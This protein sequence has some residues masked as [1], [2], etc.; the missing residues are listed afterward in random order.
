[1]TNNAQFRYAM[2]FVINKQTQ[3]CSRIRKSGFPWTWRTCS[4]RVARKLR[5]KLNCR[6][7]L[8]IRPEV[9]AFLLALCRHFT[10]RFFA[11]THHKLYKYTSFF[12]EPRK[13]GARARNALLTCDTHTITWLDVGKF[14]RMNR[15]IVSPMS[16]LGRR[17]EFFPV[18][19]DGLLSRRF[20]RKAN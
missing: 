3:N 2:S 14:N 6:V 5:S 11:P 19:N 9:C 15:T 4:T 18:V 10:C 20:L 12:F 1:M 13:E 7:Q 8:T 17:A 16:R